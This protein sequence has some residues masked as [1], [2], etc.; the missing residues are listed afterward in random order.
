VGRGATLIDGT[1]LIRY[2]ASLDEDEIAAALDEG[3]ALLLTDS[4]RKRGERW[5]TIR[6]TQGYTEAANEEPL[7]TDMSD[8]RLPVFPDATNDTQTVAVYE[9]GIEARATGYGNRITFTPE[10]RAAYAVDGDQGGHL[11]A[12]MFDGPGEQINYHPMTR[13]LNGSGGDWYNMEQEWR[14]LMGFEIARTREHYASADLGIA[15]LPL[16]GEPVAVAVLGFPGLCGSGQKEEQQ[17]GECGHRESSRS[18]RRASTQ[19]RRAARC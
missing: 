4:N 10:E 12:A 18:A 8:N 16:V 1:E 15:L 17:G 11:F 6:H 5:T 2:S 9:G 13:E 3:A 19:S 7:V 14:S